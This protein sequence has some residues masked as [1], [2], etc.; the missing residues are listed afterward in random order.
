MTQP[1]KTIGRREVL[2]SGGVAALAVAGVAVVPF[3]AKAETE[4]R[5]LLDLWQQWKEAKASLELTVKEH[6][7]VECLVWDATAPWWMSRH[8]PDETPYVA[9]FERFLEGKPI[10]MQLPIDA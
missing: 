4:D 3:A 7:R 10:T 5:E 9:T 8:L 2:R 1:E 6:G